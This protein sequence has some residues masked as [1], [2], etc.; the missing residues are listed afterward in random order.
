[1]RQWRLEGQSARAW[2]S[3]CGLIRTIRNTEQMFRLRAGTCQGIVRQHGG[4]DCE[5]VAPDAP[6]GMLDAMAN[7]RRS[8]LS[9]RNL[10]EAAGRVVRERGLEGVRIR[11]IATAA[12]MSPAA[13]LYHFPDNAA[14]I[15]AVHR[16]AVERYVSARASCQARSE[17]PRRRLMMTMIAGVPPYADEGTIRLLYELH[18]VARR[19]EHHAQLMTE[20][21]EHELQLYA[22]ILQAGLDLGVFELDAPVNTVAAMLLALEDGLVLHLVSNNTDFDADWVI[23]VFAKSAARELRCPSLLEMAAELLANTP[24]PAEGE[25]DQDDEQPREVSAAAEV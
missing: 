10:V 11:E 21:W 13:V 24:A 12:D 9:R 22:E 2:I 25:S 15:L 3:C 1:M 6:C 8:E 4:C 23:Q 18:G 20:L 17:D 14:L 5:L 16:Q 19:S 7:Y